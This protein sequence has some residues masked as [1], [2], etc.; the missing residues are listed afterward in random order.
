MTKPRGYWQDIENVKR[1]V[2]RVMRENELDTLPT[3]RVLKKLG[4]SSLVSA[5]NYHGGF[6]S[7][8]KYIG[9]EQLQIESGKW[10]NLEFV[11]FDKIF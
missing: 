8:R 1:E 4:E 7:F 3:S 10:Q 9:E 5:I 6:H 2:E 11:Y